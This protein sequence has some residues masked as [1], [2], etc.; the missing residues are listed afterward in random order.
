MLDVSDIRLLQSVVETGSLN[1]AA[2]VVHLSQPALSKKIRRLEDQ[3]G[4]Q[5]F[6][7]GRQGMVPT[8]Y[9]LRLLQLSQSLITQS[10]VL[11]RQLELMG[12]IGETEIRLGVSPAIEQFLLSEVISSSL[13]RFPTLGLK[14]ETGTIAQLTA[15][16]A[17]GNIDLAITP[18]KSSD[19]S[20][21][22]TAEAFVLDRFVLVARTNHP[23]AN[24]DTMSMKGEHF[25]QHP[26]VMP[27]LS[28][29]I[30]KRI[31][32]FLSRQKQSQFVNVECQSFNVATDLAKRS[33]IIAAGPHFVFRDFI[34]EGSL[35]ELKRPM[36]A[37]WNPSFLYRPEAS[38]S[39]A[40]GWLKTGF[41]KSAEQHGL[42]LIA[43]DQT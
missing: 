10:D 14:I 17:S 31:D 29:G 11:E 4:S 24:K 39:Q 40:I 21:E 36:I 6:Y 28:G 43:S 19:P 18:Y 7:R 8:A 26:F 5:M 22:I 9:T 2:N 12:P 20:E 32:A 33:D 37:Q 25:Y 1:K 41:R 35:V 30:K 3:L 38:L 13:H 42:Q 34:E 16:I 27:E 23:F 15:R